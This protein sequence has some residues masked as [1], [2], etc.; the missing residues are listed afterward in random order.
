MKYRNIEV[1]QIVRFLDK[2][3]ERKLPQK[4]NYAIMKNLDSFQKENQFYEKSLNK[5]IESYKDFLVKDS[6][7]NFAISDIG[8]PMVDKGHIEDYKNEIS[9]LINLEVDVKIYQ[10]PESI[11]DY[12]DANGKYDAVSGSEIL[13][14]VKIFGTTDEDKTE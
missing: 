8:V 3:S 2:I 7:G 5:I 1:V 9:E 10:V 6:E 13:K 11:F 12:E 4:I 14:F